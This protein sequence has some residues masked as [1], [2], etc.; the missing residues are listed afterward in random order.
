[1]QRLS[2]TT[3]EAHAL[4]MQLL[5]ETPIWRKLE[6]MTGLIDMT[7][8]LALSGLRAEHPSATEAELH[9]LLADR[10]LG[11]ELATTVYGPIPKPDASNDA[12]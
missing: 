2:D 1:M 8:A 11:S 3:P 9:R 12:I 6:L 7:R 10:L 5:R 4:Q